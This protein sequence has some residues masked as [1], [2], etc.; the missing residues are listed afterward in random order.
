MRIRH[1]PH[2]LHSVLGSLHVVMSRIVVDSVPFATRLGARELLER[3]R[4][5]AAK[6]LAGLSPHGPIKTFRQR[7]TVT[8]TGGDRIDAAGT[9]ESAGLGAA[10]NVY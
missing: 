1:V 10:S 9:S 2:P 4:R 3:D 5:R 7:A 8:P 6:F